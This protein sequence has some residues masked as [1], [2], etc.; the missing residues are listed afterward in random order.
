M[1]FRSIC[2][3]FALVAG[4]LATSLRAEQISYFTDSLST[5][6]TTELGRA[7]RSGVQQTWTGQEAYTGQL[8]TTTTY[9]F[10]TYTFAAA[11]FAGAP[12][13]EVSVTDELGN[14]DFFVSSFAGSYSSAARGANWLGDEGASGEFQF[15]APPIPGDSR[16]FDVILPAGQDL[17][18]LVNSTL[19]SAN[20][21]LQP[22]DIDVAAYADTQY[23]DPAAVAATPEPGTL[24]MTLTGM[25]GAVGVV[26]RRLVR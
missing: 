1:K 11:D 5:A 4:S 14:S 3:A 22:F 18:L 23:D 6:N 21:L 25:L 20:G 12:Y 10:N 15:F 19:G 8:N 7:S 13:V 16:Y 17:V 2:F 24:V 26:R 9:F